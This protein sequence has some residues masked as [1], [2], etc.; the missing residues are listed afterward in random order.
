MQD[1]IL[2]NFDPDDAI[3]IRKIE[4][5]WELIERTEVKTKRDYS[6]Y[7]AK[8]PKIFSIDMFDYLYNLAE[9]LSPDI[10]HQYSIVLYY[11]PKLRVVRAYL[12]LRPG[13]TIKRDSPREKF[14]FWFDYFIKEAIRNFEK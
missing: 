8:D 14:T 6:R 2:V 13:T 3:K 10:T 1:F 7:I 11:F 9:I 4:S 5:T 12:Y